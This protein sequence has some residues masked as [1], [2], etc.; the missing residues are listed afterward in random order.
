MPAEGPTR[1]GGWTGA[2][3]PVGVA[4]RGDQPVLGTEGGAGGSTGPG[5]GAGLGR[6]AGSG[7]AGPPLT[8]VARIE[9]ACRPGEGAGGEAEVVG[10][11]G[12]A[13]VG[14]DGGHGGGGAPATS[15][16]GIGPEG[17]PPGS[18]IAF[19]LRS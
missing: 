2:G 11:D 7:T 6:E 15:A 13:G 17:G 8:G 18:V 16:G 3:G 19:H 9:G 4:P 1:V 12:A 5:A 14:S 10:V